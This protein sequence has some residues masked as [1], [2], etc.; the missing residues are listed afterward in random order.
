MRTG[1]SDVAGQG[2]RSRSSP[3]NAAEKCQ[4]EAVSDGWIW[5][6]WSLRTLLAT[7]PAAAVTTVNGSPVSP[8][9]LTSLQTVGNNGNANS[10]MVAIDPYDSQKVFAVWGV[11]L[12]SLTPVPHTN[13]VVRGSLFAVMAGRI[14]RV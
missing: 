13:A 5:K 3:G 10:P 7:I 12:S 11:D 1:S 8:I 14:G 9:N 2:R 6:V 4:E